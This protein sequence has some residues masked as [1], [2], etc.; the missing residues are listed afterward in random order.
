MTIFVIRKACSDCSRQYFNDTR[1]PF[2][3][4]VASKTIYV[5]ISV[6]DIYTAQKAVDDF[7]HDISTIDFMSRFGVSPSSLRILFDEPS[8]S[9]IES[10]TLEPNPSRKNMTHL[11]AAFLVTQLIPGKNLDDV[12]G[13]ALDLINQKLAWED[14]LTK[15]IFSSMTSLPQKRVSLLQWTSQTL[16]ESSTTAFFGPA[17]LDIDPNIA[18]TFFQFDNKMWKLLYSVP[19]PWSNDMLATKKKLHTALVT[20]LNLPKEQRK[21]EA[22]FVRTYENEMRARG[23]GSDDIARCLTMV[24][25][26]YV[27]PFLSRCSSKFEKEEA[28]ILFLSPRANTNTWRLCFWILAYILQ[29]PSLHAVVTREILDVTTTTCQPSSIPS[30]LSQCQLL[31]AVYHE[32]LRLVNSPISLRHVT[33]QARTATHKLLRPGAQLMIAHRQLLRDEAVFGTGTDSFN[34]ERFLR[35]EELAKSRSFTPFGGGTRLCP[36]RF[37]A[38]GEVLAFVGLALSR[39]QLSVPAEQKFPRADLSNGAGMGI[40]APVMGHDLLVDVTLRTEGK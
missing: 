36:G 2:A 8:A 33:R 35:N 25:W 39:F 26:V 37:M 12:R 24:L 7:N 38:K 29:D 30:A 1:E 32:V 15:P 4:T 9:L 13:I 19:P 31:S 16:V 27:E 21:G 17:L 28:N 5:L 22:W 40:L 23:I 10:K 14:I 11:G 3:V 6:H 34:P 18:D 20:Y